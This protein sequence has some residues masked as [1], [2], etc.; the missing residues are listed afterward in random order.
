MATKEVGGEA[1]EVT[2]SA[3]DV[4]KSVLVPELEG[5][6]IISVIRH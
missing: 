1:G 4:G 2:C 3:H 6:V 5:A